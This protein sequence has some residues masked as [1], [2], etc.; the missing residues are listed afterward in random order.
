LELTDYD[1]V[2]S[3]PKRVSKGLVELGFYLDPELYAE[4]LA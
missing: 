1:G 2:F 3:L 4:E